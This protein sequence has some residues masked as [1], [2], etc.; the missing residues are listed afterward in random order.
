MCHNGSTSTF[1]DSWP[2]EEGCCAQSTGLGC[3][4]VYSLYVVHSAVSSHCMAL[5]QSL[6]HTHTH[7]HTHTHKPGGHCFWESPGANR[8]VN[9]THALLLR[10]TGHRPATV[11]SRPRAEPL[12]LSEPCL[13]SSPKASVPTT[14]HKHWPMDTSC[15]MTLASASAWPRLQ[16]AAQQSLEPTR[17]TQPTRCPSPPVHKCSRDADTFIPWV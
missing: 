4:A 9:P 5:C 11:E 17:A 10:G 12:A 14:W 8:A 7:T 3:Q 13:L 16:L 1:V 2:V 6:Q 15:T